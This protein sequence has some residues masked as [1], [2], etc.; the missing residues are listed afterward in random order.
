MGHNG[1]GDIFLAF[2]TGNHLAN[3][4]QKPFALQMLPN[5]I[6]INW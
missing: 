1:S 5:I 6:L 4:T 2:A 3:D